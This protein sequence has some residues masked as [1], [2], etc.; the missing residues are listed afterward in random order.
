MRLRHRRWWALAAAV[1]TAAVVVVPASGSAEATGRA[2][3]SRA[4]VLTDKG[5]VRGTVGAD[6]RE[7]QG[8]P[9]A[10]PPVGA[11]RWTA[12]KP[13][14]PWR[15]VLDATKPGSACPQPGGFPGDKPSY[16][17]NCLYLNVTAPRHAGTAHL[18]V[19]VWL[20]GGGFFEGSGSVYDARR[21]AE[22]GDVIV[23]TVNY[24]LAALGFLDNA[25]L[26]GTS[27]GDFGLEDQQAAL[28]WVRRNADAFGGDAH[29]VTLFGESAGGVSVCSHLTAPGSAGLFQRAI[30][31]SGACDLKWPY[32]PSWGPVAQRT[33]A[34]YGQTVAGQLG[35][36]DATDEAA[37]LRAKSTRDVV[38]RLA[39]DDA[40]SP[41][42]GGTVL[43]R[44]PAEAIATGRFARV[45]V[46]IGSTHDEYRTFETE[47]E[48]GN[49]ALT[50]AEYPGQLTATFGANAS[51]VLARYPLS[52]YA[53]AGEAW[54]TVMTDWVL[55]C[56]TAR[57]D[58][59]LS[60]SVPTYAY[61]F[62]DE[63][64][65]W[66]SGQPTPDFPTGAAHATELQYLFDG[67]YAG[68]TMS[69]GQQRLSSQMIQYWTRFA[70]TGDP[71]V[72]GAPAWQRY[73]AA[74]GDVQ[75]LAPGS[76]GIHPV[77][78]G[79]EHSCA[80]WQSIGQ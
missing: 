55:A 34:A 3:T 6:Y 31:M 30:I 29:D 32:T 28:R 47:I 50:A 16:D 70:H 68:G 71:D 39:E 69:S 61:E 5:P 38:D 46:M 73:S 12:P 40:F 22:Q 13:A 25:A 37:C 9:Y 26:G 77:N 35:C 43:P 20:H 1:A 66:F 14:A 59:E 62:A 72:A 57:Y 2:D 17:E 11:L 33:A 64:A 60:A 75:S 58:D 74:A 80:F 67:A 15:T 54:S 44:D 18:P 23:V 8:I 78:L 24:R 21:M 41:V 7:F 10:A 19:M 51:K 52:D 4:V 63:D 53:N 79:G 56:P 36:G 27:S 49:G 42:Y 48:Q 65:P 45:P 76:G